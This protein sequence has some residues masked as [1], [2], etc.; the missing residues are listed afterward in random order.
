M[1]QRW[2]LIQWYAITVAL[3]LM[4]LVA[5]DVWRMLAN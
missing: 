4:S 5:V 3:F 1:M 2:M